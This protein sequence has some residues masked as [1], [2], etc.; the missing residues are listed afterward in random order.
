MSRA[1]IYR[2][3]RKCPTD[4]IIMDFNSEQAALHIDDGATVT[5]ESCALLRNSQS[6]GA[7]ISLSEDDRFG[8]R[9]RHQDIVVRIKQCDIVNSTPY[10]ISAVDFVFYEAL[11]YSDEMMLVSVSNTTTLE[12]DRAP[13]D[14]TGIDDTS[15]WL[16]CTKVRHTLV[17]VER[18]CRLM[19]GSETVS[20]DEFAQ[21][22]LV[23]TVFI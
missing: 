17:F 1:Q 2:L 15:P 6:H 11:I 22:N 9:T 12:L 7:A 19:I 10:N 18:S 3:R 5:L 14:R 21:M 23:L 8:N 13:K 16:V 20:T 4:L